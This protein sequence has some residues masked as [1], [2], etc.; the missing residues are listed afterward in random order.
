MFRL[1]VIMVTNEI[2]D[3]K[4]QIAYPFLIDISSDF[5]LLHICLLSI[6]MLFLS[7]PPFTHDY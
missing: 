2:F 1:Y 4:L 5:T 7:F 3:L 6:I